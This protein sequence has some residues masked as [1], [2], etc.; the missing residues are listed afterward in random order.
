LPLA[1]GLYV[2][3]N[4]G[5]PQNSWMRMRSA[6]GVWL[7]VAVGSACGSGSSSAGGAGG[8]AGNAPVQ[9]VFVGQIRGVSDGH[10]CLPRPL[11]LDASNHFGNERQTCSIIEFHPAPASGCACDSARGR[12]SL[13]GV[14]ATYPAAVLETFRGLAACDTANTLACSDY[15]PCEL[16]QLSGDALL[17]CET[18]VVDPGGL[19]G[20]CYIDP[21]IDLDHDGTPDSNPDILDVCPDDLQR[22]LRFMGAGVPASDALLSIACGNRPMPGGAP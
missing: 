4:D 13:S 1:K 15:C 19:F 18:S 5:M 8:A 6:W 14:T 10:V 11:T 9:N 2:A 3:G 7:G 20:V 17:T 12:L 21:Q 22:M 16:E